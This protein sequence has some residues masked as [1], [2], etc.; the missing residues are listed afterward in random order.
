MQHTYESDGKV[1]TVVVR[2]LGWLVDHW[3]SKRVADEHRQGR[4]D[5]RLPVEGEEDCP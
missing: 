4:R 5:W 2:P 1:W 3:W